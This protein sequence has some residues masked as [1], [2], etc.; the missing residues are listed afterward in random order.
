MNFISTEMILDL[1]SKSQ[2]WRM[3]TNQCLIK[4][5]KTAKSNK[6][7]AAIK[8]RPD[9]GCQILSNSEISAKCRHECFMFLTE[10][11]Q[12]HF[13]CRV[14]YLLFSGNTCIVTSFS[15]SPMDIAKLK[16]ADSLMTHTQT[17]SKIKVAKINP[18]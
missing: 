7:E 2:A 13:K 12:A 18:L 16:T 14:S 11:Q 9:D 4:S 17:H 15:R 5:N 8:S 3:A 6:E 1:A 10:K